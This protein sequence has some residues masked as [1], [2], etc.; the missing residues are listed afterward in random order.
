MTSYF[1][2]KWR[3]KLG[4]YVKLLQN[5]STVH[6]RTVV[7]IFCMTVSGYECLKAK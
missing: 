5:V 1:I 7:T 3:L 4:G 2:E 6:T